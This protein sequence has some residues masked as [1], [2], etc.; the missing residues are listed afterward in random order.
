MENVTKA[1]VQKQRREF[2]KKDKF[3]QE[4]W[5]DKLSGR[6]SDCQ[7]FFSSNEAELMITSRV[8]KRTVAYQ[9]LLFN[10]CNILDIKYVYDLEYRAKVIPGAPNGS[11]EQF[12]ILT[13]QY[14]RMFIA[15][16]IYLYP[17][18]AFDSDHLFSAYLDR[19]ALKLFLNYFNLH[20]SAC[21]VAAKGNHILQQI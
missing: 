4:I 17:F 5:R 19:P 13:G 20:G 14:L 10:E 1:S 7:Y 2:F 11:Y 9:G 6:L 12:C 16:H 21:T 18:L 3:I 8:Q 15:F